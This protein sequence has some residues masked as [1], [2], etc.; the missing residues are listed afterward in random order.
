MFSAPNTYKNSFSIGSMNAYR[1]GFN[2]MERDDEAK[3][4][5]NSYTTPFRQYDPRLGRW[6]TIDPVMHH[7]FVPYIGMDNNPIII[8]DPSGAD[9]VFGLGLFKSNSSASKKHKR[10]R[11]R[12]GRDLVS[13]VARAVWAMG[14]TDTRDALKMQKSLLRAARRKERNG[15]SGGWGFWNFMKS[16]DKWFGGGSYRP[17]QATNMPGFE[18]YDPNRDYAVNPDLATLTTSD[19]VKRI[20]WST[21]ESLDFFVWQA[22]MLNSIA[23]APNSGNFNKDIPGSFVEMM[24][25]TGKIYGKGV[26]K[27]T[28]EDQIIK[29]AWSFSTPEEKMNYIN[30]GHMLIR[31]DTPPKNPDQVQVKEGHLVVSSLK[32]YGYVSWRVQADSIWRYNGN[33]GSSTG[34][35]IIMD[36]RTMY[37]HAKVFVNAMGDSTFSDGSGP[38]K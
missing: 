7:H 13:S 22:D 23:G 34:G 18:F 21:F 3:G 36:P 16:T 12:Y 17:T 25:Q 14:I 30:P 11:K 31:K 6:L 37:K 15:A 38:V 5:G 28:I 26:I 2:G 29:F 35:D 32:S 33:L 10:W 1:Y 20:E 19:F 24:Y 9:G 27:R 8:R 4:A